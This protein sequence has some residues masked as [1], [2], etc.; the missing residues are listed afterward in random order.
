MSWVVLESSAALAK[1]RSF[2]GMITLLYSLTEFLLGKLKIVQL[3]WLITNR[4]GYKG[5]PSA[6]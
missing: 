2:V 3:M 6:F 1:L 4:R 5:G